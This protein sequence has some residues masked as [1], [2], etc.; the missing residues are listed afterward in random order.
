MRPVRPAAKQIRKQKKLMRRR[1]GGE[2]P[3]NGFPA[4]PR[5]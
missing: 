4:E 1:S 3:L 2:H 5:T